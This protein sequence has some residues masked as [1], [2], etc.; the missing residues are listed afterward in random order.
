MWSR[1]S[2]IVE[3]G[4]M[5]PKP[6]SFSMRLQAVLEQVQTDRRQDEKA[7]VAK[8]RERNA[9]LSGRLGAATRDPTSKPS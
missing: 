6:D 9:R 7:R 3:H 2:C 8:I 5:A 4:T 1:D